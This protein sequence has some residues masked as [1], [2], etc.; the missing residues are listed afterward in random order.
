MSDFNEQNI[1]RK[2]IDIVRTFRSLGLVTDS[3]VRINELNQ[4]ENL[5]EVIGE[6]KYSKMFNEDILESGS[7]SITLD[8]KLQPKK[9]KIEPNSN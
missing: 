2:V 7:F 6:Y 3:D 9:V 1:K 4:R 8:E 5:Y